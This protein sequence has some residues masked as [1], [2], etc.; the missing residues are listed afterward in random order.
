MRRNK[1]K[2]NS[3]HPAAQ[4]FVLPMRRDTTTVLKLSHERDYHESK[5][6]FH[7]RICAL[8]VGCRAIRNALPAGD[9][10][11]KRGADG[12]RTAAEFAEPVYVG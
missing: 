2:Q 8:S 9:G 6:A 12:R 3:A 1:Q 5:H 10:I 11:P 7:A 4:Q